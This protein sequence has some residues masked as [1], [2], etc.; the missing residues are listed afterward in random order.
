MFDIHCHMLPD[1]DDG[2]DDLEESLLMAKQA[3]DDGIE[4]VIVTPHHRNG[5]FD[6]ERLLI[7]SKVEYIR[8]ALQQHNIPL[9]VK[10]GQE[11][12]YYKYLVNDLV[13]GNIL[14]LGHSRYILIELPFYSCP[15]DLDELLFE[16]LLRN[17][18]PVIAHPERNAE[19][20]RDP[21][22][23]LRFVEAGV[24][25]QVNSDSVLGLRGKRIQQ[26]VLS[27]CKRSLVHCVAS[28]A[29]G[30]TRRV[31]NLKAAYSLIERKISPHVVHILQ[32]N[33]KAIW[34]NELIMMDEPVVRRSYFDNII[35]RMMKRS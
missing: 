27:M 10:A 1:L 4:G 14:S 12:R 24:C 6:T 33:A 34:E 11:I 19:L 18:I 21:D 30:A 35:G 23:L 32:H 15:D 20:L 2:A 9:Q 5:R 7:E 29:H 31:F 28:D 17:Y 8:L 25:T 3:V 16:L 22:K 13:N 26:Y